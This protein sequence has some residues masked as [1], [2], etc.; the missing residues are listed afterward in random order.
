[1]MPMRLR[2]IFKLMLIWVHAACSDFVQ[3]RLPHMRSRAIDEG[4]LSF[5]A[6]TQTITQ[7][8]C[9]L[10]ATSAPAYDNDMMQVS[11]CRI[12]QSN[13]LVSLILLA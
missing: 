11:F 6:L 13:F 7:A 3:Q 8:R 2:H 5:F 1:M 12:F 4:N 9:K 10:Q